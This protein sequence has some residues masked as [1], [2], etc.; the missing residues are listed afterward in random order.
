M[1]FWIS[2]THLGGLWL[3]IA[4]E[5]KVSW[6]RPM[7]Y[8]SRDPHI[9]PACLPHICQPP[10]IYQSILCS[11][12]SFEKLKFSGPNRVLLTHTSLRDKRKYRQ[13]HLFPKI[14]KIWIWIF[15]FSQVNGPGYGLRATSYWHINVRRAFRAILGKFVVGDGVEEAEAG[16]AMVSVVEREKRTEWRKKKMVLAQKIS[17]FEYRLMLAFQF[18]CS[19]AMEKSQIPIKFDFWFQYTCLSKVFHAFATQRNI[20]WLSSLAM[21]F[22]TNQ[23][24][25][26]HVR[27]LIQKRPWPNNN[28]P[29]IAKSATAL[30]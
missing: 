4:S 22:G 29:P 2:E 26:P 20:K 9:L 16:A 15:Q 25:S 21:K 27:L 6:P 17:L 3:F 7:T 10:S 28:Q 30:A 11:D 8:N 1:G 12:T 19:K 13:S 24:F 14:Q 5:L 18:Q 23:P